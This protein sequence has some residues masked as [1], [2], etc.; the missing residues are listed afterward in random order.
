MSAE[1]DPWA[2]VGAQLGKRA[3]HEFLRRLAA[4][5]NGETSLHVLQQRGEIVRKWVAP[6][7]NIDDEPAPGAQ[8][9]L[10]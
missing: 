9:R 8:S 3:G 2:A 6:P 7:E 1:R 4:T 5:P 10:T